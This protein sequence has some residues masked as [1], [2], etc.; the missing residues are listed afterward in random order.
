MQAS[1]GIVL[2]LVARAQQS[3]A[4]DIRELETVLFLAVCEG[5]DRQKHQP[6]NAEQI[7]FY[8]SARAHLLRHFETN[9]WPAEVPFLAALPPDHYVRDKVDVLGGDGFIAYRLTNG[10]TGA[11]RQAHDGKWLPHPMPA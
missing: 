10:K 8:H 7:A 6:S 5:Y 1:A 9:G 2:P 4:F 11:W 3:P